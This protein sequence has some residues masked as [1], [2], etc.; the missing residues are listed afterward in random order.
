WQPRRTK[1]LPTQPDQ[2]KTKWTCLEA[3]LMKAAAQ[4]KRKWT[5][6][7]KGFF[8]LRAQLMGDDNPGLLP[9]QTDL[10]TIASQKLTGIPQQI[11]ADALKYKRVSK[12]QAGWLANALIEAKLVH[13]TYYAGGRP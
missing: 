8:G 1:T 12:K 13:P 4:P 2:P 7:E 10:L 6:E 11:A 5:D 9:E 3:T